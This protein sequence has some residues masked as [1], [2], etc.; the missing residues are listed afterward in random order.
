MS[1]GESLMEI[2][3]MVILSLAA[4]LILLGIIYVIVITAVDNS[5]LSK[6]VKKLLTYYEDQNKKQQAQEKKHNNL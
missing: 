5:E 6:N 2:L 4:F 1:K 3:T